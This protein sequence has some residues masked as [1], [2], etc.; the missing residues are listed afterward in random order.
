[1]SECDN[2]DSSNILLPRFFTTS[3]RQEKAES[4]RPLSTVPAEG[5]LRDLHELHQSRKREANMR[6][7]KMRCAQEKG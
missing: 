5:E 3:D 2:I 1:M 4:L 6:V 7:S